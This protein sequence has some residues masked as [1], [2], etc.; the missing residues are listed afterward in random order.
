[1]IRSISVDVHKMKNGFMGFVT[2]GRD[3]DKPAKTYFNVT[4]SSVKRC[5]RAQV[6][7]MEEQS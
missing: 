3:N 4:A 7:L 5:Q 6:K 2:I 1:M